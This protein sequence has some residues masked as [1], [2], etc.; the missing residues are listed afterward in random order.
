MLVPA[1][2]IVVLARTANVLAVPRDIGAGFAA[3]AVATSVVPDMP[4]DVAVMTDV[5]T[6]TAVARPLV[7]TIVATPVV[8]ED[9]STD[10]VISCDVPSE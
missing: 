5:P 7:V 4:P 8:P 2:V 9:Q 10:P 6:E 1:L 3:R